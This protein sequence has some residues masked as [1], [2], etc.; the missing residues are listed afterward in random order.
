MRRGE[1]F[2]AAV[3][4]LIFVLLF[5]SMIVS[6]ASR[7]QWWDVVGIIAFEA[8]FGMVWPL[9]GKVYLMRLRRRE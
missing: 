5:P 8:A 9:A 1:A 3:F 4:V 2:E 6:T 7:G